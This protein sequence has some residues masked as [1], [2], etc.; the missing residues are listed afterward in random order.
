V[1]RFKANL[2]APNPDFSKHPKFIQAVLEQTNADVATVEVKKVSESTDSLD[3]TSTITEMVEYDSS[4][5]ADG[6]KD[7]KMKR[8]DSKKR[9]PMEQ[10][11]APEQI[12]D[13]GRWGLIIKTIRNVLP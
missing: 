1:T 2:R 9:I 11:D 10:V 12:D 4:I 8:F 5:V 3:T 6:E 7:R 13:E